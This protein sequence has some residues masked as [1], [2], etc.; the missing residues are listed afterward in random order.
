[1]HR[2][3]DAFPRWGQVQELHR[4]RPQPSADDPP[5]A[6]SSPTPSF[7]GAGRRSN[8]ISPGNFHTLRQDFQPPTLNSD[9]NSDRRSERLEAMMLALNPR[10]PNASIDDPDHGRPSV[11]RLRQYA[12]EYPT[13]G[14][15]DHS[16][17]S[18]AVPLFPDFQD[19]STS[20][21]RSRLEASSG[22]IAEWRES[23]PRGT[24]H[25]EQ[26]RQQSPPGPRQPA[27]P[28]YHN[29]RHFRDLEQQVPHSP[30][31]SRQRGQPEFHNLQQFRQYTQQ[32]SR[33]F[34]LRTQANQS[35]RGPGHR[36][37]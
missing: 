14:P 3:V 5:V 32:F 20:N 25:L 36:G 34:Q 22:P 37:R 29:L 15:P 24:R 7:Q 21:V 30:Q 27:L 10:T 28:A 16:A 11:A 17:S 13:S 19:F 1:M 26:L 6:T 35:S 8:A 4:Q 12:S 23:V 33:N 31:G 2:M 9:I 18:H